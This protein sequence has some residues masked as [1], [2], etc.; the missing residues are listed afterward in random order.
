MCQLYLTL[1]LLTVKDLK[2][3]KAASLSNKDHLSSKTTCSD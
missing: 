2:A 1:F 3:L